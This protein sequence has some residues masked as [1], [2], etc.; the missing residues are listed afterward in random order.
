MKSIQLFNKSGGEL[1]LDVVVGIVWTAYAGV[2]L[3]RVL[4]TGKL[5]DLGLMLFFTLVAFMFLIRSPAQKT[6]APWETLLALVGAFLPVLVPRP[7]SGGLAWLGG[8]IQTL[9]LAGALAALISLGRSFAIAPADRGL[10]T[11]G[12][13]GWVRHPLYAMEIVFYIGYLVA[14]PSWRN[15]LA[16]SV[17]AAI[18]IIRIYLEERILEGYEGYAAQVRWRLLP[19]VW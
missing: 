17:T 14:N 15:T 4:E 16:L 8:T 6:G 18:Q 10:K 11:K 1:L 12:L 19:F 9:S 3:N 5:I 13:Y 7:A 2:Y